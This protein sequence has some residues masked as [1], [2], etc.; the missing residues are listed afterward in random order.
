MA[1]DD[2][3]PQEACEAALYRRIAELSID[4]EHVDE[5]H[6]LCSCYDLVTWGAVGGKNE[7]HNWEFELPPADDDNSRAVA[8]T[9]AQ[10]TPPDPA[11]VA[12]YE[13]AQGPQ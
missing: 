8:A 9:E 10:S 11:K 12:P 7:N 5:L 2:L 6:S 1:D 3:T 4:C 13:G